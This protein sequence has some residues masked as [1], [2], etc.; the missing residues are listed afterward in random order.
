MY[1]YT[2]KDNT[3][4]AQSQAFPSFFET[5]FPE[6]CFYSLNSVTFQSISVGVYKRYMKKLWMILLLTLAGLPMAAQSIA[7]SSLKN[8]LAQDGDTIAGLEIERRAKNL[9][10]MTGGADYKLSVNNDNS[11]N[12]YL[13]NRCFLVKSDSALYINCKRQH[14]K[15]LRFGAWYAPALQVK[16][17]LYFS[18]M[19]LG[20]V[21]AGSSATMDVMLGG[22][23]GD[24]IAA[25][26]QVTKRVYYE[27]DVATGKVSFVGKDKML[28]LLNDYPEW[29][30]SYLGR[31]SESA[32]VTGKYLYLLSAQ[33]K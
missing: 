11:I 26:G 16:G 25:S 12:K 32:E 33:E 2:D 21:A 23:F 30:S 4:H 19:P 8:F 6:T 27:I 28:L 9:I 29:K 1:D 17:N 15:K 5:F 14:Y 18:A 3:F 31:N 7:Y 24:A 22:S 13:K 10:V 20:S